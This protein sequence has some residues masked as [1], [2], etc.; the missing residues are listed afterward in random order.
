M[1]RFKAR[2]GSG[3]FLDRDL[4]TQGAKIAHCSPLAL[5]YG[6]R[7]LSLA[8]RHVASFPAAIPK[9]YRWGASWVPGLQLFFWKTILVVSRHIS[10]DSAKRGHARTLCMHVRVAILLAL[11][12]FCFQVEPFQSHQ[13]GMLP[14]GEGHQ[15][16]LIAE[17]VFV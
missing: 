2:S 3:A 7:S 16:G 10:V 1:I 4:S 17:Q 14:R 12:C 5:S 9:R 6:R 15:E 8:A 13:G 11:K